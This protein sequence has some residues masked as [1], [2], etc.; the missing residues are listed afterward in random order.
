[1][2]WGFKFVIPLREHRS[3]IYYIRNKTV[4][5]SSATGRGDSTLFDGI[6][7]RMYYADDKQHHVPHIHAEFAEMRAV[8]SIFRAARVVAGSVEWP[9]EVDLSYDTLYFESQ[10]AETA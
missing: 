9:G 2:K 7:I 8:F 4:A 3:S 1:M 10:A 5:S 6:I